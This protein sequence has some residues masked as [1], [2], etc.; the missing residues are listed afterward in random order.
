MP[1]DSP[2]SYNRKTNLI[3]GFAS[4][5]SGR[6][7][8]GLE[9]G[10]NSMDRKRREKVDAANRELCLDNI[11][12]IEEVSEEAETFLALIHRP[13]R[14]GVVLTSD[15]AVELLEVAEVAR[16]LSIALRHAARAVG[17][18]PMN[19]HHELKRHKKCTTSTR[20]ESDPE[21]Q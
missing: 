19:R 4:L 20:G 2:Y 14:D 21:S 11:E 6:E 9:L 15:E 17:V 12:S 13:V 7:R 5:K 1:H 16:R 10:L 18:G 3:S 8:M